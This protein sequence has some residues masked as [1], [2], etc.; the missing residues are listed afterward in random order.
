LKFFGYIEPFV[1]LSFTI[2]IYCKNDTYYV[3]DL[4]PD[5]KI[6]GFH[7]IIYTESIVKYKNK[8]GQFEIGS[9]APIVFCNG[10]KKTLIGKAD[11][12]VYEIWDYLINNNLLNKEMEIELLSISN[13]L[14]SNVIRKYYNQEYELIK[15][16]K[17]LRSK[18]SRKREFYRYATKTIA[19]VVFN[20]EK[21]HYSSELMRA[22]AH[23][24]RLR[25]LE[26]IDYYPGGVNVN[27]I[28]N[29]LNIEQSITSQHLKI[30]KMAGVIHT[31][32]DGKF[33]TYSIDYDVIERV[34]K[35][36]KNFLRK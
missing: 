33:V 2:P 16:E 3:H 34:D 4:T 17:S 22:M 18:H 9:I 23:P 20:N 8:W 7:N 14:R 19:K 5:F 36:I 15:E 6:K 13:N 25:I 28:Y 12:I 10:T 1:D 30:L 35:A 26:Y 32:K 11:L 21:L 29:T 27:K 31:E 24:L